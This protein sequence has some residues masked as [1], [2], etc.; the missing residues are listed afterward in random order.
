MNK[1]TDGL[2]YMVC[3]LPAI[4]NLQAQNVLT[5][6]NTIGVHGYTAT[7]LHGYA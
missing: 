1:R 7:E 5:H 4:E 3:D 6:L 2:M